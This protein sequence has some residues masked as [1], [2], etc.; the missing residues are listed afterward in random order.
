MEH[1]RT[2]AHPGDGPEDGVVA[3]GAYLGGRRV[4]DIAI[5]GAAA[6]TAKEGHVVWIGLLE[7]SRPGSG[8]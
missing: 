7:P 1:S 3:A 8:G 6:W 4:A 2:F 5:G